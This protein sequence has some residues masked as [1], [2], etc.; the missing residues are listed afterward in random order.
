[1]NYTKTLITTTGFSNTGSGAIT[2]LI[3]EFEGVSSPSDSYEIRFLYDPD[4]ISDL[5]YYVVE[6]PHRQNSGYAILR[7]KDYIDFN[8]NKLL[9]PHYERICKGQFKKLS[10]DFIDS[11]T[12]FRYYGAS[13]LDIQ[14]KGKLYWF[15]YRCYRKIVLSFLTRKTLPVVRQSLMAPKLLYAPTYNRDIFLRCAKDYVGKVLNYINHNDDNIVIIDQFFPPTNVARYERYIPEEY[16][17]KVFIVDRDPRDLY[18]IYKKIGKSKS[19]PCDDVNVFCNWFLWTRTQSRQIK[20]TKSVM[21]IQ[22]EDLIYDYEK[23]RDKIVEFCGLGEQSCTRKR[24]IFKPELSINNTQTWKRFP[25]T[26]D[27][28]KIIER[29]LVAFCYDF[30]SKQ[31]KPDFENGKMFRC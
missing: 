25:D 21:R 10:Y 26:I 18:V 22:F 6:N 8:T 11:I 29:R 7:F 30:D 20:D 23:T 3:S 31:M 9:N 12:D 27:D 16:Q 14:R 15:I 2:H 4:S 5:E 19:I 13:Y 1:M 17:L 24:T 28:I